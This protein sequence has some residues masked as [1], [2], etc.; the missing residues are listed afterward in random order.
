MDQTAIVTT[1]ITTVGSIAAIFLTQWL[2]NRRADKVALTTT[3]A[4]SETQGKVGDLHTLIN[5]RMT[6]LIIAAE[7]R[8]N[9]AG[10]AFQKA[11]TNKNTLAEQRGKDAAAVPQQAKRPEETP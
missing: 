11:E 6:E 4:M 2:A 5:S 1:L 8:G 7:A 3:A 10:V 9:L